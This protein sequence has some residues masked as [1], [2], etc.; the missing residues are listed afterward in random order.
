LCHLSLNSKLWR[1]NGELDF[2]RR[3]A[4]AIPKFFG[5]AQ[6]AV[7]NSGIKRGD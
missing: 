2:L 1:I 7:K 4:A 3:C 6:T 5:D